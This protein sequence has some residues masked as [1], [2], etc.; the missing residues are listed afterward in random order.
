MRVRLAPGVVRVVG[1][2]ML[3]ALATSWRMH[4][5]GCEPWR[6]LRAAGRPL[7]FLL[8]HEVLLPLLWWHRQEG[9]A[10]VVSEAR[11]GRYLGDYATRLGYSPL[12]GSSTRGGP[13]AVAG[14]LRSL[15]RGQPVA[16]TPDGPRGPR[17]EMKPGIVRL[18]QRTGARIVP[19]HARATASWRLGSWDRLVVPRPFAR[20]EIHCGPAFDVA[21]G[22][23]GLQAGMAQCVASLAALEQAG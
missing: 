15:A 6:E 22:R 1:E 23:V 11:E 12:S 18:A 5:P 8:W 19:L 10:I 13:R 9:I 20:V 21:E 4:G 2:P 14:A 16:V 3:T 17:R 7:I